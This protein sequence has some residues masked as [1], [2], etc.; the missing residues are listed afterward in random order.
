VNFSRSLFRFAWLT[1]IL[2]LATYGL[3]NFKAESS[4]L[5]LL[6]QY[7]DQSTNDMV[8]QASAKINNQLVLMIAG[9]DQQL[10]IQHFER[11]ITDFKQ[12]GFHQAINWQV[13]FEQSTQ[14]YQFILK[15]HPNLIPITDQS[16]VSKP[17]AA[18]Y[19]VA[20]A[21]QQLYGFQGLSALQLSQDPLFITPRI[22]QSLH[23][24]NTVL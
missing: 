10:L 5:K 14:L 20:K 2:S 8:T 23:T 3:T 6:P 24:L 17:N 1:V 7:Q 18:Q 21:Q 16:Y 12:Q 9:A 11:L 15:H 4:L 19:M 13:D 22:T